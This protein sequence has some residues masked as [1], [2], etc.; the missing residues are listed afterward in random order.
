[1]F[2]LD[3]VPT[4][5]DLG[6]AYETYYTHADE[7]PRSRPE[8]VKRAAARLAS[9][10]DRRN[11]L[12]RA[13]VHLVPTGREWLESRFAFL[14][15]PPSPGARLLDVGCGHGKLL[16]RMRDIGWETVGVDVDPAA[17]RVALGRGLDVRLGTLEQQRFEAGSFDAVYL[18]HVIEHVHE[19]VA[20]LRECHRV[21]K[22]GGRL[23][24]ATPNAQAVGHRVFGRAWFPLDPPRHLAIFTEPAMTEAMR[25]A[26]FVDADVRTSA[27]IAF[28]TWA[29]GPQIRRTG[30]FTSVPPG[31]LASGVFGQIAEALLLPVW[32]TAGEELIVMAAR[33]PAVHEAGA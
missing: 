21:L 19:P 18:S 23:V 2:W 7:T 4:E 30:R 32:R 9:A 22:P 10:Y 12:A 6:K 29:A 31:S 16:E 17:F 5:E 1:M 11:P 8:P 27:R 33:S 3:P 26:G 28:L 14:S 25:R 24:L 20:L 13:V 15:R